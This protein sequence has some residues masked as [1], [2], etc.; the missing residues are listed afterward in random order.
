MALLLLSFLK[1]REETRTNMLGGFLL[2]H[3][4]GVHMCNPSNRIDQMA[5][6]RAHVLITAPHNVHDRGARAHCHQAREDL[7]HGQA[8]VVAQARSQDHSPL[9]EARV[10]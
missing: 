4:N 1:F 9:H 3:L 7:R 2:R 10:S 6:V 8:A 5:C